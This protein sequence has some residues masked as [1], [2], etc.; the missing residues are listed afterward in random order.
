MHWASFLHIYQPPTQKEIWVRRAA[1]ES[2]RKIVAGA[3]RNPRARFTLNIN[4]ILCELLERFGG[5]DVL[6]DIRTLLHSGQIELTG[7]AK[8][9]AFLPL[10]PEDEIERQIR[11][12]EETL[13]HYFGDDWKKGGFFPPEMGYSKKVATVAARLGYRWMILDEL[14]FPDGKERRT[15]RTY[16]IDG[17]GDFGVFFRERN[18]SFT[19]L[20]AQIGTVPTILRYLGSRLDQRE[21]A[22]TAMD[23]ET[24]GHHRPGLDVF[25]FELFAEPKLLPA[26]LS[27]LRTLFPD[28]ETIEPRDSTWAATKQDMENGTPFSRWDRKDNAIQQKQ[29]ELTNLAIAVIHRNTAEPQ[30]RQLLDESLH[31]DQ[32]WW[33][34]MRPWWSL[35]MIE[36]GANELKT[37]ILQSPN[38]TPEE[39][40][41]AEELYRDIIYTG[42]EWQR[43]GLVDEISRREDEEVQERLEA[44][45]KLFVTKEEYE[46]MISSL[47][48][49]MRLAAKAEE[50]HRAA[51]IQDRIRELVE[52]MKK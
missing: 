35:E 4:G 18:L 22:I 21:Y 51:M 5:E 20:S 38:A 9:H 32:Y 46:H 12:N 34:S 17:L 41:R 48:E 49:Q 28:R 6:R 30:T 26:T 42:F 31:S 11:L 7:S 1:G 13:T 14:A 33:A 15:D 45:E 29:W 40:T 10:L 50:Y 19:I 36:R 52:E 27:D 47:M 23:G 43:S 39:K 25:L 16:T 3:L 44:K 8:Y 24:F 37:V 2:Y